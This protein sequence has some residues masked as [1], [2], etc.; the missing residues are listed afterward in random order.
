MTELIIQ[1]I[2]IVFLVIGTVSLIYFLKEKGIIRNGDYFGITYTILGSLNG[3]EATNENVKKILREV[4]LSV[5][6]VEENFKD[7]DNETK[8]DKALERAREAIESFDFRS[9]INDDSIRYIIRL[10]CAILPSTHK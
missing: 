2:F 3:R 7:E 9:V 10:A 6:F 1:Y 5:Q 4:S 8:E